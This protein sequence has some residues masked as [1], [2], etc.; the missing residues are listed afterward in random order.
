MAQRPPERLAH[1]LGAVQH[2]LRE[3]PHGRESL[4]DRRSVA[5]AVG[6]VVIPAAVVGTA[7]ALDDQ[8]AVDE[9]VDEADVGDRGLQLDV[10]SEAAQDEA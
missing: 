4:C 2:V 9:Q 7:V 1:P 6:P 3:E 5:A 10:A 8:P